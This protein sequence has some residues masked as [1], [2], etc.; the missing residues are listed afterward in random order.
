MSAEI[1]ALPDRRPGPNQLPIDDDLRAHLAKLPPAPL[2]PP[3]MAAGLDPIFAAIEAH[4]FAYLAWARAGSIKSHAAHGTPGYEKI[5][6]ADSAT[7]DRLQEATVDL[8][9]TPTT[10]AGALALL[11]YV[12]AFNEGLLAPDYWKSS[13]DSWPNE[14][15]CEGGTSLS[16]TAALIDTVR[17]TL[18]D[19]KGREFKIAAA[20]L[21]KLEP[22]VDAAVQN[23]MR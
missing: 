6:E 12:N 18:D 9:G 16:F 20:I 14:V 8:I 7:Y 4:K 19:L 11:D 1:I 5:E 10:L 13:V 21:A 22:L 2:P 3:A 15:D 17:S 23:D